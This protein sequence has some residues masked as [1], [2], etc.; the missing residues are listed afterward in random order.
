MDALTLSQA[1]SVLARFH[2]K[3]AFNEGRAAY[4]T[5]QPR[6]APA[7]FG[8]FSGDWVR[9]WEAAAFEPAQTEAT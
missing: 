8:V 4:L 6:H 3:R 7:V 2:A 9:G 1:E 5:G